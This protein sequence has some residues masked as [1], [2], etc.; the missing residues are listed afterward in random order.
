MVEEE[1][2]H[3]TTR[4]YIIASPELGDIGEES[5]VQTVLAELATGTDGMKLMAKVWSEAKT[6]EVRR[7]SPT[8]TVTGKLLPLHIQKTR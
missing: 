1:D 2:E 7:A 3:S 4:L 6:L 5:L 8:T